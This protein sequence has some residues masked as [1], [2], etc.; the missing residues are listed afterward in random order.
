MRKLD[1]RQ[2]LVKGKAQEIKLMKRRKEVPLGAG[3]LIEAKHHVHL[4]P[5]NAEGCP[6]NANHKDNWNSEEKEVL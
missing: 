3:D 2:C 4:K 5:G 6:L 1:T